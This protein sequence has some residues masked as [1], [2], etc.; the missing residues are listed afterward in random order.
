MM[1]GE[2]CD[3]LAIEKMTEIVWPCQEEGM[4]A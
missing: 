2:G 4:R 3:E 1:L